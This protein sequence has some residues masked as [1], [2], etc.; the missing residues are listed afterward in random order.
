MM[1][2][3]VESVP[4]LRK[5][6]CSICAGSA[7]ELW[8]HSDWWHNDATDCLGR[9]TGRFVALNDNTGMSND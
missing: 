4:M 3:S 5:G 8:F 1:I 7:D 9:K 2:F 6:T